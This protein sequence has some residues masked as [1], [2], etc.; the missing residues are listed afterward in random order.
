MKHYVL[1][2]RTGVG[3]SSFINSA[4]GDHLAKVDPYE[5]CTKVVDYYA[6]NTAYGEVCLIDT[7]GMAEDDGRH[8]VTYLRMV[9]DRIKSISVE[10]FIY[11]TPLKETRFR[12]EEQEALIKITQHLGPSIWSSSWLVFTFAASVPEEDRSEAV[13]HHHRHFHSLLSRIAKPNGFLGG[14]RGFRNLLLVDNKVSRWSPT[15]RP[16]ASFLG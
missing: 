7:P 15:C 3:K 10:A 4:F 8:D 5:A 16:L 2:G 6:R 12:A 14:F 13:D 9:L 1:A 11:V